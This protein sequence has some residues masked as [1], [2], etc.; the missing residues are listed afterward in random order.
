MKKLKW[1]LPFAAVVALLG[2]CGTFPSEPG[3]PSSDEALLRIPPCS[4]ATGCGFGNGPGSHVILPA[5]D[6][7]TTCTVSTEGA[8]ATGTLSG[9]APYA[10]SS[11]A[12]LFG[13]YTPFTSGGGAVG[14]VY[15]DYPYSC[16]YEKIGA[17]KAGGGAVTLFLQTTALDPNVDASSPAAVAPLGPGTYRTTNGLG[18]DG[19][20]GLFLGGRAADAVDMCGSTSP[21]QWATGTITL[22]SVSPALAGSFDV[23][24]TDPLTG[25]NP[26]HVAGTFANASNCETVEST[27][28]CCGQTV[29]ADAGV[30]GVAD[31]GAPDVGPPPDSGVTPLA[32]GTC[33]A[34]ALA[35]LPAGYKVDPAAAPLW[36]DHG[37]AMHVV[38]D[39]SQTSAGGYSNGALVTLPLNVPNIHSTSRVLTAAGP[40]TTV[41]EWPNLFGGFAADATNVYAAVQDVDSTVIAVPKAGGAPR[42][43]LHGSYNFSSPVSDGS[44]VYVADEPLS[45]GWEIV[46]VPVAGGASTV[47]YRPSNGLVIGNLTLYAGRLFWTESQ[48]IVGAKTPTTIAYATA[49]PS[50]L[51]PSVF[52]TL[53]LSTEVLQL[54]PPFLWLPD[55]GFTPTPLYFAAKSGLSGIYGVAAGGTPTLI[56]SGSLLA[57]WVDAAV[58]GV[59]YA[60]PS[61]WTP[62]DDF[63]FQSGAPPTVLAT[64]GVDAVVSNGLRPL[65]SDDHSYVVYGSQDCL[66][67]LDVP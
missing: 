52:A 67:A 44:T 56:G 47:V 37:L 25:A 61:P 49:S 3:S 46:A 16:G 2:A 5:A 41:Y 57:E 39:Y 65:A 31:A 23:T 59:V 40:V 51:A 42:V 7:G 15:A 10:L 63:Q 14:I 17:S 62:I 35:A 6:A 55:G 26:H 11:V 22:T 45:S 13:F 60:A 66:Y 9:P 20:Y 12:S 29:L 4:E 36:V 48:P 50:G 24:L 34:G 18:N 19:T 38:P 53:P 33:P 8:G 43:L 21:E 28:A 64:V 32:L 30:G 27:G 54:A 1:P 58:S